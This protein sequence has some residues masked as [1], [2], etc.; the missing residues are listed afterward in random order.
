MGKD[1]QGLTQK[2][3]KGPLYLLITAES[4][5]TAEFSKMPDRIKLLT[6][7]HAI[8]QSLYS[9]C[10]AYCIIL[11]TLDLRTQHDPKSFVLQLRNIVIN[12]LSFSTLALS[13]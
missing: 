5:R 10:Q 8:V 4:L 2:P 11:L 1:L 3:L 7:A 12:H 9:L 13:D 6:Q